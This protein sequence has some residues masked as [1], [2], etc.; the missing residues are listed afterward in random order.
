MKIIV[1]E[2][3]DGSLRLDYPNTKLQS[4]G[5]TEEQFCIRMAQYISSVDPSKQSYT[6]LEDTAVPETRMNR[7]GW[8]LSGTEITEN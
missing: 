7:A 2:N 5:E 8:R 6:I 3:E 4:S 1:W